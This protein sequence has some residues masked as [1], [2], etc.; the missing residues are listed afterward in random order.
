MF[1]EA[2][3]L[4]FGLEIGKSFP[5]STV[6]TSVEVW[7]SAAAL[8]LFAARV[9]LAGAEVDGSASASATTGSLGIGCM[10]SGL[11]LGLA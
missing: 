2:T 4:L 10:L 6:V 9:L 8:R 5:S 3:R 7:P 11:R 1:L